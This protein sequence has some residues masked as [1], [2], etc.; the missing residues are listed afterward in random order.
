MKIRK[1]FT[2]MPAWGHDAPIAILMAVAEVLSKLNEEL[3]GSV[4]FILQPAE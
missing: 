1:Q 2:P 4:K 3:P